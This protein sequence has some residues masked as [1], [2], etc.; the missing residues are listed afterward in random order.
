MRR[1]RPF[2]TRRLALGATLAIA[3]IA[4][5]L[6]GAAAAEAANTGP[7][8]AGV[9]VTKVDGLAPDFAMGVDVSSVLSLEESG[10]VFRDDSGRPADLFAVLAQHGVNSV[11]IRV[12]NDPFD[13][14]TGQGYGGGNV[15]VSRAVEIGKRAAAAGL[16]VDV[17]FQYSDFWADP[18]RQ[19]APKAWQG[20]TVDQTATALHDF[21]VSALNRFSAAGVDVKLVQIGNETNNGIAGYTRAGTAIDA[22]FAELLQAGSSAVR[23][24][25]PHALVAVHFT[26]P[27]TPGRYATYAAGLKQYGVDYDV[28]ASSY[29][30]FW[31]G[32]TQNLTAVLS[33]IATT[34]GK[35][36][37]VAETSWVRTLDDGDGF[38]NSIGQAS[39]APQYPVSVQGQ[40]TELR[41]VIA[42]VAAVGS[43]GIGVYYWEPAWL[44]VG[45]PSALDANR[46]LWEKFGSGWATSAASAYDPANVGPW[47]GGSSWDNQSLF[48]WSGAPLESLSTFSY[49]RTGAVAPRAVV[50]VEQ[51]SITVTDGQQVTLP[52]TVAVTYNDGSVEHPNVKWSKAVDWIRGPG[53]YSI[54]GTTTSKQATVATVSVVAP[55][56]VINGGFEDADMSA[57]A[58]TG[59][60]SRQ[61]TSDAHSG[62]SA[63]TF[64]NGSA[65]TATASQHL[66]GVPA[67]TYVLRA[68]TQG[69]NSP[70]S[71]TRTL[72]ART[73][74]G[75]YSA[76]LEMTSWGQFHTASVP[77]I[78]VGADGVVDITASF[79]LSAGAWGVLD[80]VSL[81]D[82]ASVATTDVDKTPLTS[83]L[84]S[85]R[86]IDRSAY[87]AVSLDRLD[88]AVAVG[89]VV[90][91]GSRATDRDVAAATADVTKAISQLKKSKG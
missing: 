37:M 66:T 42:A 81:V 25:L 28:F 2:G 50:S 47:Y 43:A 62:S 61:Q 9:S 78:R 75:S 70:A 55:E 35:K 67:G 11:R 6:G 27:E 48:S 12:W 88:D 53:T 74:A 84:S 8:Q 86:S 29:Y 15:D 80:D 22:S 44:P 85:A 51:P 87:S 91:A 36:V 59:P 56:H 26:N 34:Y 13:D 89:D 23:Q 82:A 45:P 19:L 38:A 1:R 64:W 10:V 73:A 72:T 7:V 17:D 30:P 32:A 58:L 71:D 5:G 65:Y 3:T 77:G 16:S 69:T 20:F 40:A 41:D 31:H 33:Q 39:Q 63:V 18:G 46:A 4:A 57:W 90:V 52:K 49:V 68:T 14:S 79:A 24:V 60:A 76:P 54:P 83:A 21:T